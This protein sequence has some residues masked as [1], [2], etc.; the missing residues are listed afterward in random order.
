MAKLSGPVKTHLF[1]FKYL[2]HLSSNNDEFTVGRG[3]VCEPLKDLTPGHTGCRDGTRPGLLHR[4]CGAGRKP[5][6][7]RREMLNVDLRIQTGQTS[8]SWI[9]ADP[10]PLRSDGQALVITHPHP[11]PRRPDQGSARDLNRDASLDKVSID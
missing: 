11:L 3:T 10:P 1:S 4:T 8:T 9:L 5:R 6:Q 2:K 7:H